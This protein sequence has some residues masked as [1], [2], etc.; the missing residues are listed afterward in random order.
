LPIVITGGCEAPLTPLTL[1]AFHNMGALCKDPT[2]NAAASRP[3]D[4]TR[5]G[6]VSAEGA[7]ILV[8][9]SLQHAHAR[10]ARIYAEITGYGCNADGHHMTAPSTEGPS[11]AMTVR[12]HK[13]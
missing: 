4:I 5:T 10:K 12:V 6:F 1:T 8:L 3:F 9:E 2:P 7:A 11:R 13:E